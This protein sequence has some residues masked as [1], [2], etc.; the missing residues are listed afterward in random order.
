M[1]ASPKAFAADT[2]QIPTKILIE[3]QE[4]DPVINL[5]WEQKISHIF[6]KLG[7]F[8]RKFVYSQFL[9]PKGIEFKSDTKR[10][11]YHKQPP[12]N[13][14]ISE[15]QHGEL[16]QTAGKLIESLDNINN[17]ENIIK[18]AGLIESA[19]SLI[20][21]FD[22]AENLVVQKWKNT[23]RLAYLTRL[24]SVTREYQF[25]VPSNHRALTAEM[26]RQFI[27][28]VYLK[29]EMLG[30]RFRTLPVGTLLENPHP[31]IRDVVAAEAKDRECDII[32]TDKT[33]FLVSPASHVNHNPFSIRRFLIE[34]RLIQGGEVYLNVAAIS[35]SDVLRSEEYQQR[36][37]KLLERIVKLQRQL[38]P[39]IIELVKKIGE[40]HKSTLNEILNPPKDNNGKNGAEFSIG[41]RLNEFQQK[42]EENILQPCQSAIYTKATSVDD[43]EYLFFSM[44]HLLVE[45]AS[46]VRLF[47][48][49]SASF[50]SKEAYAM[51]AKILSI[52]HYISRHKEKIFT[53]HP[54]GIDKELDSLMDELKEQ[55]KKSDKIVTDLK[56]ELRYLNESAEQP[57]SF[58]EKIKERFNKPPSSNEL[59]AKIDNEKKQC[60]LHTIR[61]LKSHQPVMLYLEFEDVLAVTDGVRHYSVVQGEDGISKLPALLRIEEDMAS[62]E[63]SSIRTAL[64]C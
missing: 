7:N 1:S 23:L 63:V 19:V 47:A 9:E 27:I 32:K 12:L 56:R 4:L 29:H 40:F 45:I 38:S 13:V 39:G 28:E 14:V 49:R 59:Q 24:V 48:A 2:I 3:L 25:E 31:F 42:M 53:R 21:D 34:Q 43:Y 41:Y 15:I 62:F 30:F 6:K 33:L 64:K 11:I 57:K 26:V 60:F 52:V 8:E 50:W 54:S 35:I 22:T 58:K 44:R 55:L 10:F 18:F 17:A 20:N 46:D 37:A 36:T 51:E 61:I 16:R 5:N